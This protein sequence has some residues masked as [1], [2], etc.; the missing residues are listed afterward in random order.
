MLGSAR[1]VPFLPRLPPNSRQ[2]KLSWAQYFGRD[3]W[4]FLMYKT[5]R[6]WEGA[7]DV[8]PQ[9]NCFDNALKYD[10]PPCLI[11]LNADFNK[12]SQFWEHI[13]KQKK[14]GKVTE[15]LMVM[16]FDRWYGYKN[17]EPSD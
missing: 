1:R 15:I 14:I 4:P 2:N 13:K 17:H 10:W 6:D 5:M 3:I 7:S 11:F 16:P 8:C 12:L 9:D